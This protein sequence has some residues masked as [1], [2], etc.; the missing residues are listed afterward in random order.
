MTAAAVIIAK[1]SRQI[2]NAFIKAGATSPA[3]AKSFQEMGITDNL[4]FEIKKLE[5]V[6]VRTG[7][8]RFYLDIDRHRKVKR[9]ALLIVF[10]VLVVV[11]V[12]S[13]YLNGVRI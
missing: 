10:A 3:D 4:I 1:K 12:I 5:G 9:N 7:Q 11:M 13:L 6:I 2:I 8:D